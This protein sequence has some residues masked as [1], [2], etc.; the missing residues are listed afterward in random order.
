M[1]TGRSSFES[2]QFRVLSDNNIEDIHFATL[3][4]LKRTGVRIHDEEGLELMRRGGAD[5]SDGTLVRIP[6]HL[7]EWALRSAPSELTLYTRDGRPAMQL[8]NYEVYYGTGP[9]LLKIMDPETGERRPVKKQDVADAARLCDALTNIDF[10]MSMGIVSDCAPGISDREEFHAM[11]LNTRKPIIAWAYDAAGC[12]D[13]VNMG[14]MVRGSLKELQRRPFFILYAQPSSPLQHSKESVSKLLYV[15]GRQ[16]PNLYTPGVMLGASSPV[17]SAGGLVIANAELITGLVLCQL[18]SEGAPFIYGGGAKPLDLRT[19]VVAY[20]SPEAY[21]NC[22]AL[23][24]IAHHYHIPVW[25][26]GGVTDSKLFDE[27]AAIEGSLSTILATLSGAN[28][29]H[30]IGYLESAITGSLEMIAVTDEVIGMLKRFMLGIE[31]N[32]ET[33][34]MDLIGETSLGSPFLSSRHTIEHCRK[35]RY[36]ALMDRH[37]YAEW[38]ETGR[39]SLAQRANE[40]VREILKDYEPERLQRGT[41]EK[42]AAIMAALEKRAQALI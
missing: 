8:E 17:T 36:P 27:Q 41:E 33:L 15:A 20:G 14:I 23:A 40:R 21:I 24:D 9:S 38:S 10:V 42:L 7:A 35:N 26:Y 22:A 32:D 37:G 2:P 1:R 34:G 18:K 39:K 5:I 30:D 16:L 11:V 6:A 29:V 4:V 19:M 3:E 28:L 12:A 31:V 13:I 25:G